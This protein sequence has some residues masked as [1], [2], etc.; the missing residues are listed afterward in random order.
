MLWLYHLFSGTTDTVTES[1]PRR[2]PARDGNH[3][4]EHNSPKLPQILQSTRQADN[5]TAG[6]DVEEAGWGRV[7]YL[8]S[9]THSHS[10]KIKGCHIH[11]CG[12][13]LYEDG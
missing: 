2:V 9:R 5:R 1:S 12:P 6:G 11:V 4:S 7:R 13:T 3:W 8:L 10:L